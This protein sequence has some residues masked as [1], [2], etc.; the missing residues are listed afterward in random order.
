LVETDEDSGEGIL[1]DVGLAEICRQLGV[2][3]LFCGVLAKV[4]HSK[5]INQS[6]TVERE[7]K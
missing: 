5:C 2:L 1:S 3:N 6:S 7:L 4:M